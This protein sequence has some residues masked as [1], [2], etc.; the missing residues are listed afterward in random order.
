VRLSSACQRAD[1]KYFV[2]A[3]SFECIG[4]DA[5]YGDCL[6]D[7]VNDFNRVAFFS[8]GRNV[9]VNELDQIATT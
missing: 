1:R 3:Q 7:C 8:T 5:A 4:R 6:A 9:V 2:F